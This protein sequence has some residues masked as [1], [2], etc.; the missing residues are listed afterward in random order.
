MVCGTNCQSCF[1]FMSWF[2]HRIV[3]LI[4]LSIRCIF[5][6]KSSKIIRIGAQNYSL[7]ALDDKSLFN[8]SL[9]DRTLEEKSYN[10]L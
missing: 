1:I 9:Q 10:S 3:A 7:L 6:K 4:L 5:P 2:L 8:L